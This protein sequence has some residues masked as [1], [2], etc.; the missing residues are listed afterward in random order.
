LR[1]SISSGAIKYRAPPIIACDAPISSAILAMQRARCSIIVRVG[2]V[3][4]VNNCR[5]LLRPE[6]ITPAAS[7]SGV[8]ACCVR[9]EICMICFACVS[10]LYSV[11]SVAPSCALCKRFC[12]VLRYLCGI[13]VAP[14]CIVYTTRLLLFYNIVGQCKLLQSSHI[15]AGIQHTNCVVCCIM[16]SCVCSSTTHRS[17]SIRLL[18]K[19]TSPYHS[20]LH[21]AHATCSTVFPVFGSYAC[22]SC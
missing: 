1:S 10:C 15:V 14:Q 5:R 7:C 17:H 12:A 2:S 16:F 18:P 6:S 9:L 20:T 4:N 11:C 3:S 22:K 13:V 19:R 8:A 21:H